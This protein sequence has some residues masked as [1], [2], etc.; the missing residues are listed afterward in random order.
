MG[1]KFHNGPNQIEAGPN[2]DLSRLG[3]P[4]NSIGPDQA[5]D[6]I[7]FLKAQI[8]GPGVDGV[9][10]RIRAVHDADMT[11]GLKALKLAA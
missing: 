8:H 3:V 9:I 4:T 11:T 7:R 2:G 1:I 5:L 6:I 10:A